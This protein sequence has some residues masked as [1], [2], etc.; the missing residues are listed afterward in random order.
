MQYL[1]GM[2]RKVYWKHVTCMCGSTPFA[3]WPCQAWYMCVKLK[4]PFQQPSH[5]VHNEGVFVSLCVCLL[6]PAI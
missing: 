4:L 5:A 6:H 3:Y 1:E 2:S